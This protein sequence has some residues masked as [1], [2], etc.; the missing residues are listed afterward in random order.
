MS[1]DEDKIEIRICPDTVP[2]SFDDALLQM[3]AGC[4]IELEEHLRNQ[5]ENPVKVSVNGGPPRVLGPG[6]PGFMGMHLRNGWA[7]WEDSPLRRDTIE[8][9]G[10]GHADDICQLLTEGLTAKLLG[11]EWKPEETVERIRKHWAGYGTTS[12][13]AAGLNEDG[14]KKG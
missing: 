14:T 6:L 4:S 5:V 7:L 13:G 8:R 2:A 1:D 11:L 10:I 9:W 12:C 3:V